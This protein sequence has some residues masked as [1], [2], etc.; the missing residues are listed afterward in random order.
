M[1]NNQTKEY[2]NYHYEARIRNQRDFYI[3]KESM[4]Q[5]VN[6]LEGIKEQII[7]EFDVERFEKLPNNALLKFNVDYYYEWDFEKNEELG[8]DI[9][10]VTK[11]TGKKMWW[12]CNDCG[13]RYASSAN[14]RSNGNNGGTKCP[15]CNG[16]KKVNHTNSLASLIPHLVTQW[17]FNKNIKNPYTIKSY[18]D[19]KAWWIG[20]C[21]HEWETSVKNRSLGKNCPYCAGIKVLIGFNDMWT[22]NPELAKLLANTEDGYKYMQWSSKRLNWKCPDCGEII[23]NKTISNVNKHPLACPKC[24]DG[25]KYPEKFMYHLLNELCINFSYDTSLEWSNNKRY[26]F[27]IPS[28]NTIIET[29]GGQ[30]I[31]DRGFENIGGRTL[32]EEQVNDKYKYEL[33]IQNGTKPEDYIVIDCRESKFEFIKNNIMESRLSELFDLDSVNWSRINLNATRSLVIDVCNTYS[34]GDKTIYELSEYFKLSKTTI[35][36][37]LRKGN[38]LGITNYEPYKKVIQLSLS[39][40]LINTF[41]STGHASEESGIS[42]LAIYNVLCKKAKTSGGY[43]WMYKED[44]DECFT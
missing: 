19:E 9:W 2:T 43:I 39:Y 10:E 11:G 12:I 37:Y 8:L 29:H 30:H 26:D 5:Y 33:A 41:N 34:K 32:E 27:Y 3:D 44:Y 38:E 14:S 4:I 36:K 15:Y 22:T 13:S 17:I 21:G 25:I 7:P 1:C 18:S 20:E 28:L 16:N 42:R 24:S 31:I 40:N 35:L 23:K 6:E